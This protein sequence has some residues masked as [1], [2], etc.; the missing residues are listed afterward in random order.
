[1]LTFQ[2]TIRQIDLDT[3]IGTFRTEDNINIRVDFNTIS[4]SAVKNAFLADNNTIIKIKGEYAN[5]EIFKVKY[6][7]IY[8][9]GV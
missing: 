7:F 3:K 9:T 4:I 6:L 2:G 5:A 8:D 1:M